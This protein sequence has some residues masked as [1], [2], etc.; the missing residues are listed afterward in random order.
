MVDEL[1]S[2]AAVRDAGGVYLPATT[3]E[4]Y[5]ATLGFA[6]VDP[7][8]VPAE[9]RVSSECASICPADATVTRHEAVPPPRGRP[10]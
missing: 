1:L 3:A 6:T 2:R 5:F 4:R 10:R 7:S 9:I 8:S